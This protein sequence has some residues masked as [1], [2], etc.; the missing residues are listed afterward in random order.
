MYL[1]VIGHFSKGITTFLHLVI[2]NDLKIFN[3]PPS[4]NFP[5]QGFVCN[6]AG[7]ILQEGEMV[8]ACW[9]LPLSLSYESKNFQEGGG[10]K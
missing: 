1:S 4:L 7:N 5:N 2:Y 9:S 3:N 6:S 8:V 10:G